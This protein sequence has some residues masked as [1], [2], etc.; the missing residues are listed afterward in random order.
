[1]IYDKYL[2]NCKRQNLRKI[3]NVA[4]LYNQTHFYISGICPVSPVIRLQDLQMFQWPKSS[5]NLKNDNQFLKKLKTIVNFNEMYKKIW[6][7]NFF[8]T[9]SLFPISSLEKYQ[10]L[11]KIDKLGT[12]QFSKNLK[13]KIIKK[14]KDSWYQN[15][16]KTIPYPEQLY[17][18][19]LSNP[20]IVWR[21][22]QAKLN[23]RIKTTQMANF[24]K[25]LLKFVILKCLNAF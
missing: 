20:G 23:K 8:R 12:W 19:L 18:N 16:S 1:M 11:K 10:W 24:I 3:L 2:K 15:D 21:L 13:K 17:S 22:K 4:I 14:Y 25:K 6:D 7:T 5:I 9:I